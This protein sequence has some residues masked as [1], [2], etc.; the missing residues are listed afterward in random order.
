MKYIFRLTL[1]LLFILSGYNFAKAQ[2]TVDEAAYAKLMQRFLNDEKLSTQ[3]YDVLYYGYIFQD[4]YKGSSIP[5]VDAAV[6][7]AQQDDWEKAYDMAI[8]A[9]PEHPVSLKL[10]HLLVS[11]AG[12][13]P[14]APENA[15]EIYTNRLLALLG[16]ILRSGDG[17]GKETAFWVNTISDE[18]IFMTN[19]LGIDNIKSQRLYEENDIYYDV[20]EIDPG[21]RYEGT[22]IWFDVS[23]SI[24]YMSQF[25]E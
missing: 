23:P 22:E 25:F 10:Y 15:T 5:S 16:A 13:V 6:E 20:F 3:E 21:A 9:I 14:H 17:T 7:M 8:L 12:S 1:C 11:I 18:Y 2:T 19:Y 4:T 24:D